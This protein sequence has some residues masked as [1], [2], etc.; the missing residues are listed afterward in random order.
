MAFAALAFAAL[1][2]TGGAAAIA[3][4]VKLN[5]LW[6]PKVGDI[7][8][9]DGRV[10]YTAGSG[11]ETDRP[12]EQLQGLK[13]DAYPDMTAASLAMD[14]KREAEAVPLLLKVQSS[15]RE[16]WLRNWAK[17]Q[18]VL[19]LDR[20]GRPVEAVDLYI[21]M[22]KGGVEVGFLTRPPVKALSSATPEQRADL[23]KKIAAAQTGL[24]GP[25]AS[26]VKKLAEALTALGLAAPVAAPGPAPGATPATPKPATPATPTPTPTPT[27]AT[28]AAMNNA[29]A[30]AAPGPTPA[31]PTPATPTPAAPTTPSVATPPPASGPGAVVLP[32]ELREV[33][34]PDPIAAMLVAGQFQAAAD[35]ARAELA[36]NKLDSIALRLY[37]L[38]VAQMGLARAAGND[39][40]LLLDAGL[41]FMRVIVYRGPSSYAGPSMIEAGL[42]HDMI[43]RPD[44]ALRYY[45]KARLHVGEDEDPLLRARLEMLITQ[46]AGKGGE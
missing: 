25:T 31:T 37:E 15:A 26:N 5:G 41:S 13:L 30:V 20:L 18:L 46:N 6:V 35:A 12:L 19:A 28:P 1:A 8:I 27:P 36:T 23:A 10:F 2:Q 45:T 39:R 34:P 32:K 33:D 44:I 29:P 40:K 7:K 11:A 3:D 22:V 4:E 16:P 21:Q 9:V 14:A 38:G 17:S 42:V 43:G 24:S